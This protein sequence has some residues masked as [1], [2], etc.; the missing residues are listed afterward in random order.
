M[1]PGG[2]KKLAAAVLV[3][4]VALGI[5]KRQLWP[6]GSPS[7]AS[8]RDTAGVTAA[9]LSVQP[10]ERGCRLLCRIENR[11]RDTAE[12]IVLLAEIVES[13]GRVIGSNPLISVPGMAPGETRQVAVLVP[14]SGIASNIEGRVAVSLVRWR[15]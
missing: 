6:T 10:A 7:E 9:V 4:A 2:N 5:W 15:K 13:S 12:Q 1:M 3:I 8:V 14:L 11:R